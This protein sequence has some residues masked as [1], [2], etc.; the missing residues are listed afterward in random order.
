[1]LKG[2]QIS[3]SIAKKQILNEVCLTVA[4]GEVL[5]VIGS[6]GA[7]KSTLLK[8][9]ALLTK[10]SSGQLLINGID[11]IKNPEKA[12][13]FLGVVAH[14]TYLY[15]ELTVFENLEFYGNMYKITNITDRIFQVIAELGLEFFLHEPVAKLSRGMQQRLA[16]ARAILAKPSFILLDEPQ[17]GLDRQALKILSQMIQQLKKEGT[18]IIIVT[19]LW[20]EIFACCDKLLILEKGNQTYYGDIPLDLNQ[21]EDAY[22]LTGK[23]GGK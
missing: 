22:W 14:K 20:D 7:G 10:P 13:H 18:G 8:I 12:G 15:D 23:G 9:L 16:I 17:T 21:I 2:K 4:P 19:H 6:N 3:K 1:M 5:A 11:V